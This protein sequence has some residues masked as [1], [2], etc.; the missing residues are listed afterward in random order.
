LAHS[1]ISIKQSSLNQT[2]MSYVR[3]KFIPVVR[4]LYSSQWSQ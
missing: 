4:R 1:H 2:N 3:E